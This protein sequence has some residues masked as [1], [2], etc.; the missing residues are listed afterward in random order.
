MTKKHVV[1]K[2]HVYIYNA[3]IVSHF[4]LLHFSILTAVRVFQTVKNTHRQW[5]SVNWLTRSSSDSSDTDWTWET[6]YSVSSEHTRRLTHRHTT[7]P[8]LHHDYTLTHNHYTMT[9]RHTTT[10]HHYY[11][12]ATLLLLLLQLLLAM[13]DT[14]DGENFTHLT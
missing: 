3:S 10:T 5:E 11:T 13:S 4:L 14:H 8:W 7:T 1:A 9:H 6:S 2:K 12:M